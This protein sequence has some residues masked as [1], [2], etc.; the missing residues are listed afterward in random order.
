MADP[1]DWNR[2]FLNSLSPLFIFINIFNFP[3]IM[4]ACCLVLWGEPISIHSLLNIFISFCIYFHTFITGSLHIIYTTHLCMYRYC[5]FAS[6]TFFYWWN[7]GIHRGHR[8]PPNLL[9][10]IKIKHF[11]MGDLGVQCVRQSL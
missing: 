11:L 8:L 4:G 1:P 3:S 6:K 2:V 5:T 7:L 10:N 9:I